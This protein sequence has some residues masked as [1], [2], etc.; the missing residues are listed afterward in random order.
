MTVREQYDQLAKDAGDNERGDEWFASRLVC[1]KKRQKSCRTCGPH[2]L[3]D[4]LACPSHP[5]ATR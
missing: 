5:D 4:C 3:D 2:S 1:V